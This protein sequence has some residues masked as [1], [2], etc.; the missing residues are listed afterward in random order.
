[1]KRKLTNFFL[2][3]HVI[4]G[5]ISAVYVIFF[6]TEEGLLCIGVDKKNNIQWCK[7]FSWC[8]EKLTTV[9]IRN[10]VLTQKRLNLIKLYPGLTKEIT[11]YYKHKDLNKDF[12][13]VTI[14]LT[15]GEVMFV[16]ILTLLV[17]IGLCILFIRNGIDNEGEN[18]QNSF[19]NSWR[20]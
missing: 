11:T 1:M 15:E 10:A 3:H 6:S 16:W 20:Y 9:N 12:D 14:D 17:T 13:Y 7:P 18:T 5:I 2:K 8:D 19:R 4:I